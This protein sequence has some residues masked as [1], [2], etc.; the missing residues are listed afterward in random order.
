MFQLHFSYIIKLLREFQKTLATQAKSKGQLWHYLAV[1]KLSALI[2]VITSKHH[3]DFYCLNCLHSFATEKKLESH[4]KVCE[5]K[6]DFCNVI[7]P[8]EDTKVL[9]F[10]KYKKSDKA[11][12]IIHADLECIIE[13]IDG[14]K[15]NPEKSFRSIENKNDVYRGK[16]FMKKFCGSLREHA[17]KILI[18]KRKK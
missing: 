11:P 12:F 14:F 18:L 9:E 5:K 1:K 16:D 8:S 2:R 6:K 17:M 3:G 15:N 10:N 7:M 4:K 13:K